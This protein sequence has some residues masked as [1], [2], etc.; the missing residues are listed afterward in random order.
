MK[1]LLPSDKSTLSRSAAVLLDAQHGCARA[2]VHGMV[3]RALEAMTATSVSDMSVG[4]GTRCHCPRY[5][6]QHAYARA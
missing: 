2:A 1:Q 3:R 4:K 5:R 6:M